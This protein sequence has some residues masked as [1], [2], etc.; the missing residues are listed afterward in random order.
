MRH[1]RE[2]FSLDAEQIRQIVVPCRHD[3]FPRQ[4]TL[5]HAAFRAR[6]HFKP[7]VSSA[8]PLDAF[9]QPQL[10]LIMLRRLAVVLERLQPGRLLRR[11]HQRQVANFKQFRSREE[12]HVDR[13]VE[14]RIAKATLVDHQGPHPR[15]A[16][17]DRRGEPG[18]SRPDTDQII[19]SHMLVSLPG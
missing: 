2:V 5:R 9:I 13:V 17:L 11:T 12:D 16:R 15:S 8:D 1:V 6:D 3:D 10:E 19:G 18:R 4:I 14:E 7:A